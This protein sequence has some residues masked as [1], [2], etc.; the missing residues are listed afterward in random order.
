MFLM[1]QSNSRLK[2]LERH[3]SNQSHV[4]IGQVSM[5]LTKSANPELI[6]SPVFTQQSQEILNHL[7]WMMKKDILGQDIFLYGPPGPFKRRLA[8]TYLSL[9]Q[10]EAEVVVIHPDTAAESDLK[11]R[12]E[13]QV[14]DKIQ[15]LKWVNGSCVRAA[16]NGRCLII[17]GIEKAER[18]V[19]P[20]LNNLLENREMTLEDGS[21]IISASQYD[22]LLKVHSI[23][24]LNT[25][26]FIR[27]HERFRVIAIG[28]PVPPYPGKPLD[29]P[30]RSRFQSRYID[31]ITVPHTTHLQGQSIP[32]GSVDNQFDSIAKVIGSIRLTN[33]EKQSFTKENLLPFFNQSTLEQIK[34]YSAVFDLDLKTHLNETFERFWPSS[35]IKKP[36]STSQKEI[37]LKLLER[38]DLIIPKGVQASSLKT[39]YTFQK[40]I[41]TSN[42]SGLVEFKHFNGKQFKYSAQ[43]GNFVSNP[44]DTYFNTKRCGDIMSRMVQAHVLNQDIILVGPKSSSKSICIDHFASVFGYE[45]SQMHLYRDMSTRDFLQ[46]RNTKK[47]GSTFWE[48]SRLVKSAK[49]GKL[50][51]L[52]GVNWVSGE[53]L[54][55]ISRLLQDRYILTY[56]GKL[57]FL[58]TL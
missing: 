9:I 2:M 18:N 50:L 13:I 48:D 15:E 41:R 51:V 44:L 5:P 46:R 8:S 17:D 34:P 7:Q 49:T 24:E 26:G 58:T 1:R 43:L 36:L 32:I 16:I 42:E 55:G 47:D 45:I 31:N 39:G 29:P 25:L 37:F 14:V 6:P 56:Q 11:Q 20:V 21:H 33:L 4:S 30:F 28:T 40:V 22:S 35:W 19:L 3:L 53:V 23:Q 27:A 38:F 52:E 57:R 54:A 10:Q 12:R